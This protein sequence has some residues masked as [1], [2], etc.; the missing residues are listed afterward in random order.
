MHTAKVGP[1]QGEIKVF[2]MQFKAPQFK[3]K[4][5][6]KKSVVCP[7]LLV[8]GHLCSNV[9]FLFGTFAHNHC[10][11]VMSTLVKRIKSSANAELGHGDINKNV[12]DTTII[13]SYLKSK[14]ILPSTRTK[15]P[16][17]VFPFS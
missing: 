16:L 2:V 1:L 4:V 5:T 7:V 12:L 8:L 9:P 15:S 13:C 3:V 14:I 6:V 10:W 17:D 11:S